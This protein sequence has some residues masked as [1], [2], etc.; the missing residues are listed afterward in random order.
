MRCGKVL[1]E[2]ALLGF[3]SCSEVIRQLGTSA[4]VI[5]FAKLFGELLELQKCSAT[6]VVHLHDRC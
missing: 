4:L 2:V 6:K 1:E 5:R 3:G